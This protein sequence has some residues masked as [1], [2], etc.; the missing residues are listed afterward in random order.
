MCQTSLANMNAI[1]QQR[2]GMQTSCMDLFLPIGCVTPVNKHPIGIHNNI[3]E[4][5]II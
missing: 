1:Q 5:K 2:K 4:P 3:I